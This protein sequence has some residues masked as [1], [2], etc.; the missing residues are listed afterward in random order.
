VDRLKVT[1]TREL[2]D[3]GFYDD[4]EVLDALLNRCLEAILRGV[5]QSPAKK[6][7]ARI[8]SAPPARRGDRRPVGSIAGTRSPAKSAGRPVKL[9]QG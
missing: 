8:V 6:A 1:K 5:S 7:H 2:L 9:A 3:A 4:P